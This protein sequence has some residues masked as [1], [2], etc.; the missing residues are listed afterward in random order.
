MFLYKKSPR[1]LYNANAARLL[2]FVRQ[3]AAEILCIFVN[4]N[5]DSARRLF[6]PKS[7]N[8]LPLRKF[9]RIAAAARNYHS[10]GI[11]PQNSFN[12]HR[13]QSTAAAQTRAIIKRAFTSSI[14]IVLASYFVFLLLDFFNQLLKLFHERIILDTI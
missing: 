6:K 13:S 3:R 4:K 12:G 8:T 5:P 2:E 14:L 7:A 10:L 1:L 9:D 11:F